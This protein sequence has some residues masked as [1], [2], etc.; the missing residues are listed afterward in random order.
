MLAVTTS[1]RTSQRTRIFCKELASIFPFCRY[2][3]RGKKG[4]RELSEHA[5]ENGFSKVLVVETKN[6]NPCSISCLIPGDELKWGVD[7]P[8]F[9]V[10][11]RKDM[12]LD[13]KISPLYGECSVGVVGDVSASM[14]QSLCETFGADKG[15]ADV[16]IVASR[17]GDLT[18]IDFRR[19]GAGEGP[20]GPQIRVRANEDE[21]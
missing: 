12:G 17:S 8:E 20:L 14:M 5:L 7:F 16:V 19:R 21:D 4:V 2:I 18:K 3:V 10:R 6:G 11:T 15:D 13:T 9:S 1:R